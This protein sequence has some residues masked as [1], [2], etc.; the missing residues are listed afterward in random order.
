MKTNLIYVFIGYASIFF[1]FI[2]ALTAFIGLTQIKYM[3]YSIALAIIG[4]ILGS[5]N[6]FINTKYF[7]ELEKYPKGYFGI[8]LSSLPVIILMVIIFKF[9]SN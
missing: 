4:F 2:G 5:I 3:F 6:V 9:K 7:S 8:L 1:G